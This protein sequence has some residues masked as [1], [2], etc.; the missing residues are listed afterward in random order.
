MFR[1]ISG[2]C[3]T[4]S[5]RF[6]GT[7]DA[8]EIGGG[9]EVVCA[10]RGVVVGETFFSERWKNFMEHSPSSRSIKMC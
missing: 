9:G 8:E 4:M 3:F 6:E 10:V 7:K 1:T 2:A 5:P